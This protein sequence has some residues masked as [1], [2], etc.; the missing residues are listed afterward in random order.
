MTEPA[1][2]GGPQ[3]PASQPGGTP[4]TGADSTV[5]MPPVPP[6]PPSYGPPPGPPGRAPKGPGLFRQA[7]STTGGLIA[8]IVAGCLAVLLVLGLLGVGLLV[9]ARVLGLHQEVRVAQAGG[10][11]ARQLM[12]GQRKRLQGV[13]PRPGLGANGNRN[14]L[15]SLL[16]VGL[17]GVQHGEFTVQG[18]NG[19]PRV[20]TVQRGTVTAA[21]STS[22]SVK[23][24]DGFTATYAVDSSTRGKTTNLANGDTVLVVAQKAGSKAVL[25]RAVSTP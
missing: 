6:L 16:G 15:G 25:I 19:T 10:P 8:L 9:G 21:S 11:L 24:P 5:P 2:P 12:P 1:L 13:Q 23:S 20:M 14:G 22:V 7:T 17:G 3:R 18:A 4:Q